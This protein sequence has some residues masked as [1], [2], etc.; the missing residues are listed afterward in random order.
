MDSARP[1]WVTAAATHANN[2]NRAPHGSSYTEHARTA[3]Y[4]TPRRDEA[5]PFLL[6]L[7]IFTGSP[8]ISLPLPLAVGP[9]NA[10]GGAL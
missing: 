7:Y 10:A 3:F 4:P 9:L 6:P 8:P 2:N 1:T 5:F